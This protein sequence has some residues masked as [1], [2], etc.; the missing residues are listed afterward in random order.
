VFGFNIYYD[1]SGHK[2]SII[3]PGLNLEFLH[4]WKVL[5]AKASGSGRGIYRTKVFEEIEVYDMITEG[6][7]QV[8]TVE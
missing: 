2:N 8:R 7:T 3:G 1:I 5:Q 6:K 4:D